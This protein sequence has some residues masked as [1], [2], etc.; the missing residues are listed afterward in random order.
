LARFVFV[1][2][3][4]LQSA[5]HRGNTNATYLSELKRLAEALR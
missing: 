1:W 4:L 2:D 3:A 5:Q